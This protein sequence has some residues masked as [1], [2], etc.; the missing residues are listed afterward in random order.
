MALLLPPFEF[1]FLDF[2]S[3][4]LMIGLTQNLHLVHH[5]KNQCQRNTLFLRLLIQQTNRVTLY[6]W[7]EPVSL[8]NYEVKLRF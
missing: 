2:V 1:S 6:L 8:K 4:R 5:G 3:F 7:K